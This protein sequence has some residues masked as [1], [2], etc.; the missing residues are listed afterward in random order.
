MVDIIA[1]KKSFK[2]RDYSFDIFIDPPAQEWL[3]FVHSVDEIV[4]LLEGN[5]TLIVDGK[6]FQPEIGDEVFIPANARHDVITSQ[7]SG[8]RWAF[9]YKIV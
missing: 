2:D 4:V 6:E 9:G 5:I 7:E 1:L 8:S 3:N